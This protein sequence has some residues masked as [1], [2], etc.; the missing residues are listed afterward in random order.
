MG[1]LFQHG[2]PLAKRF[3]QIRGLFHQPVKLAA[4]PVC[5][6]KCSQ[7]GLA[8]SRVL[9]G[10][11]AKLVG[12]GCQIKKIIGKLEGKP[13][14]RAEFGQ[15]FAVAI[16]ATCHDRTRFAG[17]T[18][19][20]SGLH[21]LQADNARLVGFFVLGIKIKHLAAHHAANA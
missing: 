16:G 3:K 12:I 8:G 13:D 18:K 19:Q 2:C 20:R 11:L 21:R 9:A 15:P 7:R 6:V 14:G 17:I 5:S 1:G 4:R 10:C